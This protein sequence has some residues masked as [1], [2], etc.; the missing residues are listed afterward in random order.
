[1]ED[2]GMGQPLPTPAR[3]RPGQ[4]ADWTERHG[5]IMSLAMF[6]ILFV[7]AA[8]GY[9]GPRAIMRTCVGVLETVG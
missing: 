1:M 9:G 4:D 2:A 7:V 5:S 3:Y 8:A 6:M